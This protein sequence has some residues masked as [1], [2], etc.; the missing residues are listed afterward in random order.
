MA[1]T[2][3]TS[4]RCAG[5]TTQAY[6]VTRYYNIS[7]VIVLGS[8]DSVVETTIRTAG[9]WSDYFVFVQANTINGT[10]TARSRKNRANGNQ[11]VS[12]PS[13]TT[14]AFQDLSNS[15]TISAGDEINWQA[16]PSGASSGTISMQTMNS[17]FSSDVDSCQIVGG[18]SQ[19]TR[20]TATTIYFVPGV[21]VGNA[22]ESS[23]RY[24]VRASVTAKN[25]LLNVSANTWTGSTTLK[26][27]KNGSDGNL[28]ITVPA[29]TT[30]VFEDTSNTDDY[31]DGDWLSFSLT[32]AAGSGSQTN[33][34]FK[35]EIASKTGESLLASVSS[36]GYTVGIASTNY[37]QSSST[38]TTN[39]SIDPECEIHNSA[40]CS[41]LQINVITNG[42][43]G[44][45]T[46]TSYVNA[47]DGN[48]TITV[49]SS[50]TGEL[51]DSTNKDFL[52]S[53]DDY[54][55]KFVKTGSNNVTFTLIGS[56]MRSVYKKS[57]G[58]MAG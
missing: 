55:Y 45:C 53:E 51:E 57:S 38:L 31:K 46:L 14:G 9:T 5:I 27:R 34:S 44:S 13:S 21:L 20:T 2:Y 33:Q 26:S 29:S 12:I 39:N 1:K 15:D 50:T 36:L 3:L 48:Q 41:N 7:G 54:G 28:S 30:G 17:S 56:R 6:N 8:S 40:K 24:K 42:S 18:F 25:M 11:S 58:S 22:T 16:V 52:V 35:V 47:A 49:P 32:T 19:A 37:F 10:V 4:G 23:M 43:T